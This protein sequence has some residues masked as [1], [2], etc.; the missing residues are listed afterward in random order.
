MVTV[1]TLRHITVT[2]RRCVLATFWF[3]IEPGFNPRSID[4]LKRQ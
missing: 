1:S 4:L 3:H 2:G